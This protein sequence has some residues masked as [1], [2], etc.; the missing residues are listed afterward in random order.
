V[1]CS[2]VSDYDRF[3]RPLTGF[4]E[5]LGEGEEV[6]GVLGDSE[7]VPTSG[8]FRGFEA[9]ETSEDRTGEVH[10]AEG[11]DGRHTSEDGDG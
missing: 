7:F 11:G 6:E 4:T 3:D 9:A 5:G 8:S 10:C 1:H 2:N